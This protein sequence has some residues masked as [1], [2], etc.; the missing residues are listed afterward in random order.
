[1][2]E[3]IISFPMFGENFA[4]NPPYC[5]SIGVKPGY[6]LM[7][8]GSI[9]NMRMNSYDLFDREYGD[10]IVY[11]LIPY[12]TEKYSIKISASPEMHIVSGG[13]SGGISAFCIAWFHPDFFRRVYMSSPS[14]LGLGRGNEIP[15]LIRKYETKPL[16]IY[17]ELSEK[18]PN[19]YFGASYPIGLEACRALTF[20]NYDFQFKYF[21]GEGHC[22]RY[23]DEDEAYARMK[24]LWQE[25]VW[26]G[27]SSR[28]D[29]II[30]P[31]SKW[32]ICSEMPENTSRIDIPHGSCTVAVRSNDGIAAYTADVQEDIVYMIPSGDISSVSERLLHATVHTIPRFTPK[33]AIDMA[34]DKADRLFVLTSIG[35]QCV[36]SYGQIDAIL[37]LPDNTKPIKIA[38]SDALYVKTESGVYRRELREDCTVDHTEKRRHIS[39]YD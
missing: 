26:H 39:Y 12:I 21:E 15:Y 35:I 27:N 37:D 23:S 24:W 7:S 8:D 19:D 2:R 11:E 17:E 30:P 6:L 32:E 38:I 1:M 31:C 10:F 28:V 5:I 16:R 33:G 9:R 3:A 22:S 13:S 4:I 20:A 29:K 34:V 14:F 36:R 18:E 25:R